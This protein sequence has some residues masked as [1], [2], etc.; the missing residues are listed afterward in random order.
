ML[1]IWN[2]G[3]FKEQVRNGEKAPRAQAL[4]SAGEAW[5]WTM[6]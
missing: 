6:A 2:G 4:V 1:C 3:V 5:A